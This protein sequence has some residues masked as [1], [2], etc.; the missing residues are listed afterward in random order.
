MASRSQAL[1]VV[2]GALTRK[3]PKT[4]QTQDALAKRWRPLDPPKDAARDPQDVIPLIDG[5]I[6]VIERQAGSKSAAESR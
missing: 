4:N 1:S 3:K 2:A 5:W 6:R